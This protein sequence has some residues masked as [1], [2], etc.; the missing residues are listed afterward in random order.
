MTPYRLEEEKMAVI[1]QQHRRRGHGNRFYPD[2]AG[3]ARSHNFYPTPPLRAEDGIVAVSAG[4]GPR[5]SWTGRPACASV[6]GIPR[7]ALITRSP[8]WTTR[9]RTPSVS[10]MPWTWN[11]DSR[12]ASGGCAERRTT[13]YPQCAEEDGTLALAIGSTYSPDNDVIY[14]GFSR[15]GVRLVSFC[16]GAQA[17]AVPAGRAAAASC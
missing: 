2:F 4:A 9:S 17:R 15:P 10:S 8:R 1:I 12:T 5:P 3:V 14:D 16:A 11:V 7:Q 6:R 13:V